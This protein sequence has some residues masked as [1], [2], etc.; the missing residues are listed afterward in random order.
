MR[1]SGVLP[2]AALIALTL[3]GSKPA[4]SA[5]ANLPSTGFSASELPSPAEARAI[6]RQFRDS[7]N[8][9]PYYM[10]FELRALPRRGPE[11]VYS[12]QM[13]GDRNDRGPVTRISL[14]EPEGANDR[15]LLQ[16]GPNTAVW[17]SRAAA[18]ILPDP[19]ALLAP[20]MAG[21]QL[22]L[23]DLEMPYL[24]WPDA[25][26]VSLERVRGRLAY[27]YVFR[28][29]AEFSASNPELR[30]VRAYL[31][32]QYHALVESQII[33]SDGRV[34]KTVS[35]LDLKRV[36][37]RWTVKTVDIRDELSRDKTRFSVTAAALGIRLEP[38]LFEPSGLLGPAAPVPNNRLT[39][40]GP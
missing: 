32:T 16:N 6:L 8:A 40:F 35:L 13:W 1:L 11:R 31:D 39:Q 37:E 28:P 4:H 21:L 18:A 5:P 15:Y 17:S 2:V 30:E 29:P 25:R 26:L 38:S 19:K 12:G 34:G 33:L 24:Y 20:V 22:T 14:E 7:I 10:R 9:E 23:F 36:G 27:G 3:A